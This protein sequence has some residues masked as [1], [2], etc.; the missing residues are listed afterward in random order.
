VSL[1][2]PGA[3]DGFVHFLNSSYNS[4]SKSTILKFE[5]TTID[6][7]SYYKMK[8]ASLAKLCLPLPPTPTNRA[9]PPGWKR[10]LIILQT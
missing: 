8:E 3:A 1:K 2:T 10:I 4:V 7:V 9:L 5:D 6:Y